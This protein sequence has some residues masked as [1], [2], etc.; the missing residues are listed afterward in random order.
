[1]SVGNIQNLEAQ[2]AFVAGAGQV[3]G[4]DI[5]QLLATHGASGVIN[6]YAEVRARS[7]ADQIGLREVCVAASA[8]ISEVAFPTGIGFDAELTRRVS[9]M[10]VAQADQHDVVELHDAFTAQESHYVEVMGICGPGQAVGLLK[11][12]TLN[13][14]GQFAINPSGELVA[15]DHPLGPTGVGRI[16]AITSQLRGEAGARQRSGCSTGTGA[17]GRSLSSRLCP[18]AAPQLN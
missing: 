6:D 7:I 18:R 12:G 17:H 16:G 1:M 13:F 8:P 10:A 11:N 3:V 9:E 15:M 4:L 5:A 2:V 14:D